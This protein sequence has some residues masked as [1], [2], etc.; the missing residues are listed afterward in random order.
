M[1]SK[2]YSFPIKKRSIYIHK[3]RAQNI[4]NENK[5]REMSINA[6]MKLYRPKEIKLLCVQPELILGQIED[7][8]FNSFSNIPKYFYKFPKKSDDNS[9]RSTTNLYDNKKENKVKK[10]TFSTI[11]VI[12]IVKYKKYNLATTFPKS[13]IYKN[14]E[15]SQ[16]SKRYKD[17][18]CI[19]F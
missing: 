16:A 7:K 8:K 13:L 11:E 1:S 17:S 12:R 6:K 19:S 15:N 18:M 5:P 14:L 10:V 2:I 3:K 4:L 9:S